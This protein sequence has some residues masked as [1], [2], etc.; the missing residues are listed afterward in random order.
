MSWGSV[1]VTRLV[2]VWP[3]AVSVRVTWRE[4]GMA[5]AST[6][7]PGPRCRVSLS[8]SGQEILR[9]AP[10]WAWGETITRTVRSRPTSDTGTGACTLTHAS[11]AW[12][13]SVSVWAEIR[14]RPGAG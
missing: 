7:S 14:Y 10:A 13:G 6:C 1:T 12:V 5:G 8:Q 4:P 9:V 3:V 11:V 2:W